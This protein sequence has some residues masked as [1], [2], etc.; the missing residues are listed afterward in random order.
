M[1]VIPVIDLKDGVVVHA[2]MGRRDDYRPITSPLSPSS[3]A[4][5]VARG[6]LA[7]HPFTTLYVADLDAIRGRG[8]NRIALD[9]ITTTFP[10]LTLWVDSG[11]ADMRAAERW[12]DT[13][14]G[15]LVLG[16]ETQEDESLLL[17][18][19]GDERIVLSLDFRGNDF[20]GP[21]AILDR[22]DAWPRDV[23]VMTLARVGSG[24][25]PDLARLNATRRAAP[26]RNIFAA[27]GV[28]DAA[29]LVALKAAGVAGAL[30]ATALHDG[31]LSGCEISIA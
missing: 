28:R 13:G 22:P 7:V 17:R 30:V 8:E 21:S 18:F 1:E 5:D 27:G 31:R 9:A 10:N 29:D 14:L 23:I 25:G 20:Q 12:L 24:A 16:S 26:Q 2:R 15:R 4:V 6:L 19:A 11:I 3:D